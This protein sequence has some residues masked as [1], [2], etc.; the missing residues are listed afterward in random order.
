MKTILKLIGLGLFGGAGYLVYTRYQ[1]MRRTEMALN[2]STADLWRLRKDHA[3]WSL[4]E[5]ASNR[6]AIERAFKAHIA[7]HPMKGDPHV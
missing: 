7:A 2:K 6:D 1:T 5:Y 3:A 4:P